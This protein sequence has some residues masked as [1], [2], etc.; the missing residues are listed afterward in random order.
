MSDN[1]RGASRF[2]VRPSG[3]G[4]LF[5]RDARFILAALFASIVLHALHL[6]FMSVSPTFD[7]PIIDSSE[8]LR[9]AKKL[10]ASS[11][12]NNRVY[13]HSPLYEWFLALGL[14]PG[15][16]WLTG[17]RLLGALVNLCTSVLVYALGARLSGRNAGR[18]ALVFWTLYAPVIYFATEIIN[19]PLILFFNLLGMWLFLR[20]M[21]RG[22]YT[23]WGLT[24][25]VFGLSFLTR[26]DVLPYAV[27]LGMGAAVQN[28]KKARNLR[29]IAVYALI[30]AAA[31]TLVGVINWQKSGHYLMTPR[32]GGLNFFIGNNP[33]YKNTIGIRPGNGWARLESL[34]RGA[35]MDPGND[36]GSQRFYY[37]EGFRFATNEPGAWLS[38]LGF[39]I[40][41]LVNGYELPE[42]FDLY[43]FRAISP[44][45]GALL[46]PFEAFRFPW[47]FFFPLSLAGAYLRRR[48]LREWW[49]FWGLLPAYAISL[50][51][52]WN[53]SRYRMPLVPLVVIFSA[54]AADALFRAFKNRRGLRRL[55]GAAA[56]LVAAGTL[57]NAPYGHFSKQHDFLAEMY[58]FSGL[59]IAEEGQFGEGYMEEGLN[60]NAIALERNP[61]YVH[62][63]FN[64][65]WILSEGGRAAEAEMAYREVL[66]I[67]PAFEPALTNLG[68]IMSKSGR[69]AEA[70]DY[71]TRAVESDPLATLANCYL[72]SQLDQAG[73]TKEALPRLAFCAA[74]GTKKALALNNLGIA[75][76]KLR[77]D[78]EAEAAYRASLDTD[79]D[80]PKVMTNLGILYLNG[81]R[82]EEARKLFNRVL[83]LEPSNR[84]VRGYLELAAERAKP[85]E[86]K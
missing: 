68:I 64:R 13:L 75:L 23:S 29:P 16:H 51:G 7:V 47:A 60:R 39:K 82:R 14:G 33:D 56:V 4:E 15:G 50:I 83:T 36:P 49:W 70:L 53:S 5:M 73:R 40:G 1:F 31:P 12:A 11:P 34:P 65:A 86:V 69:N 67:D 77:R 3:I 58:A 10:L 61:G 26:P 43:T 85:P 52:Y 27:L 9:A 74:Y 6:W 24:G 30:L 71:F 59:I 57:A 22:G 37:G 80:Q 78:D 54:M 19:V 41:T 72:G 28:V 18:F 8:Y 21:E 79:P 20:A 17:V 84:E 2:K 66:Q 38:C 48:R 55:I 35:G 62:A 25:L 42:S 32:N 81:G 63:A 45:M 44:V 46:W 76:Q